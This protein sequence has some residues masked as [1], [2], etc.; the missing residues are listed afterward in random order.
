MST[1]QT[2]VA[3][4]SVDAPAPADELLTLREAA[5][6][7]AVAPATLEK[8]VR[9]GQIVATKRR[10]AH[11]PQWMVTAAA[12]EAFGYV[13]GEVREDDRPEVTRLKREL[14]VAANRANRYEGWVRESQADVRRLE[15]TVQRQA[16]ALEEA[17]LLL[18]QLP[19][20]DTETVSRQVARRVQ[21]W[22]ERLDAS[23]PEQGECRYGDLPEGFPS[24]R[25]QPPD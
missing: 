5:A 9:T 7:Y 16:V 20:A 2:H 24:A 18:T 25:R 13:A 1:R 22:L 11:C 23:A 6:R 19:S 15:S 21:A 14:V 8:R 12:M 17:R 3:A 4:A 10:A